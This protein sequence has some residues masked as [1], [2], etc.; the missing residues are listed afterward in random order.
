VIQAEA[1]LHSPVGQCHFD[2]PRLES[3]PANRHSPC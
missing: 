1:G 3:D 2:A